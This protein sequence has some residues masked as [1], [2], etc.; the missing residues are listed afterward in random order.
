[1]RTNKI[2]WA[3]SDPLGV[4]AAPPAAQAL[5]RGGTD[6]IAPQ[7]FTTQSAFLSQQLINEA[8]AIWTLGLPCQKK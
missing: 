6:L 4:M 2:A 3:K 1:M 5:P 8:L 7:H